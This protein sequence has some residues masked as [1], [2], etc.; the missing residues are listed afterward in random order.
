MVVFALGVATQVKAQRPLACGES[1]S[2]SIQTNTDLYTLQLAA[3]TVGFVQGSFTSGDV[4]EALR[5]RV[6]DAGGI[7]DDTCTNVAEFESRGQPITVAVSSCMGGRGNYR[8]NVHIVSASDDHCGR[9]LACGATPDGLRLDQLGDVDSFHFPGLAGGVVDLRV[10]DQAQRPDPYLVRVY[11]P[12]GKRIAFVCGERVSVPTSSSRNYTILVSACGA[13]TTG[14]YRIERFDQR[15]PYGPTIT[16]ISFLPQNR[17]FVLPSTYDSVGRPVYISNGIGTIVVE[18]RVGRSARGVAGSAFEFGRPPPFQTIVSN[19]LGNGNA[20]VCDQS[21]MPPGGIAATAPFTFRGD[22]ASADRMNDLGCR[23]NN[24]QGLAVGRRD[25]LNSCVRASFAFVDPTTDI[26]FCADLSDTERFPPGNTILAARMS[27]LD[28]VFG[29]PREIVIRVD[30]SPLPSVTPSPT[31][32]PTTA[33][34]PSATPTRT[35][36]P[37]P[38]RPPVTRRPGPCVC[39]CDEDGAVRVNEMTRCVRIALGTTM[40]S[41]CPSGDRNGDGMVSISELVVGVTNTL[42]GCPPA[43]TGN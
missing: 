38:T 21:S 14:Q 25:P 5:I 35:W 31:L 12:N 40:L 2:G 3:G 24:G 9:Q 30:G 17:S 26:Q 39:D 32:V 7:L 18:G 36:T 15:C 34:V 28:G 29:A 37:R 23:F 11:D 16:S 6:T 41:Q 19:P 8:I 10:G 1:A 27:D 20:E 43:P 4:G 33:T 22:S 13:A 42:H